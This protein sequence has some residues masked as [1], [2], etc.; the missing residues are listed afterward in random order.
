MDWI[1]LGTSGKDLTGLG[2]KAGTLSVTHKELAKH[3][4]KDD[5]WLAIRG[6]VYN[7]TQY[8]PFHPGGE[9]EL[10]KG[11]GIDATKL[12]EQIHA[13]V[14]YEQILQKCLVGKLVNVDPSIDT[15]ALFFGE[16]VSN[17]STASVNR[18]EAHSSNTMGPPRPVNEPTPGSLPRFDW[19]Q[20]SSYITIVF[21]TKSFSNPLVEFKCPLD[22]QTFIL[23]LTYDDYIFKN[24]VFFYDKVKWPCDIHVSVETG[25]VQLK[26]DKLSFGVWENYGLLKQTST[27]INEQSSGQTKNEYILKKKVQV[28]HDTWLMKFD[29][30]DG[31]K[32]IVPVGKHL[33]VF[34]PIIEGQEIS[35]PYTA[36]PESLFGNFVPHSETNICLMVKRYPEGTVSRFI[37]DKTLNDKVQFSK[38]LGHYNLKVLDN[39]D[40]F[41]M[42]AAGTG[43][44]PMLSMLMFL[45]ERRIKKSVFVRLLFFNK[46]EQDI[47]VRAQLEELSERDNRFKVN[48]ILSQAEDSWEGLRGHVTS[49]LIET[50]LQEH[51]Q[52][53][54]YTIND[55]YSF[56][57]GPPKFN[58]ACLQEQNKVKIREDQIHVFDG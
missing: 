30:L 35:Q 57:C 17:S 31:K 48:Y 13:W 10:I 23:S 16:K 19:I 29:R 55:I 28:S 46:S 20:T 22:E 56:V 33:R 1:R 25:K 49:D 14:N 9:E 58:E 27:S 36:V 21:Y 47:L 4:T 2:S 52:D 37:T 24:E 32:I 41:L 5:A 51:M 39:R 18:L 34:G 42:L 40:T 15:E 44:S 50:S 53:T 38:P 3:N 8:F 11:A 12:F 45:L 7:V 6:K 54:G 43:I 26:F